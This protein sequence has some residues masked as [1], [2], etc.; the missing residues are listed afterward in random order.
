MKRKLK[1]LKFVMALSAGAY[2][3][4]VGT[5]ISGGINTLL[6]SFPTGTVF[7]DLGL[8]GVCGTPNFI[9]VDENGNAQGT[10]QNTED[11]LVFFCPVTTVVQQ[12][13]GGDGGGGG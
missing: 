1:I 2:V 3:M 8:P 7:T 11:D 12:T 4:Q 10:V 9:V 6:A 13:G 5:C